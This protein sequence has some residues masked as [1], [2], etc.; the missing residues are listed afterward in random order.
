M[1]YQT[2]VRAS[3]EEFEGRVLPGVDVTDDNNGIDGHGHGTHVAGT[4]AGK[5]YGVAKQA[6]IVPVKVLDINGSGSVSGK[7]Q[8]NGG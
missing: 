5:T 3:H 8:Q 4:V 2:G 6:N 7:P 1:T